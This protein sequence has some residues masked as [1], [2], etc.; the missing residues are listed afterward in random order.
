MKIKLITLSVILLITFITM[1]PTTIADDEY[2]ESGIFSSMTHYLLLSFD[3]NDS[4]TPIIPSGEIRSVNISIKYGVNFGGLFSGLSR[5]KFAFQKGKQVSINLKIDDHSPWCTPTLTQSTIST[6]ITEEEQELDATLNIK[7]DLDA[8]AYESGFIKINA[9][10]DPIKSLFGLRT[11]ISG[12]QNDATIEFT[13][14]YNPD[15]ETEIPNKDLIIIKPYNETKIP[16]EITNLGNAR[17]NVITAVENASESWDVSIE[18]VLIDVGDTEQIFLKVYA[19]HKFKEKEIKVKFTPVYDENAD[20]V[21]EPIIE[22]ILLV[23]DGS[24]KDE[25]NGDIDT[26]ILFRIIFIIILFLILLIIIKK[27]R[28]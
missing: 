23:N 2:K 20:D 16:I 17:T 13:P 5:L 8:P 26:N 25:S 10:V 4:M 22:T 24:Y 12:F 9:S 6:Q 1:L 27:R 18:N 14:A 15:I 11:I 28:K 19:D 3:S 7:V 21:G